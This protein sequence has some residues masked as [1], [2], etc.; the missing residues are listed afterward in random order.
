MYLMVKLNMFLGS[1]LWAGDHRELKEDVECFI[2]LEWNEPWEMRWCWSL[3]SCC[4]LMLFNISFVSL[5]VSYCTFLQLLVSFHSNFISSFEDSCKILIIIIME[6][7]LIFN[8]HTIYSDKP[9]LTGSLP[10]TTRIYFL[11]V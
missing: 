7:L 1:L 11:V 5:Y 3:S 9:R 2:I 8:I 10:V 4:F 6:T